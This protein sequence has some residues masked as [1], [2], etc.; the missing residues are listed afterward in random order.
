MLVKLETTLAYDS[1]N[2]QQLAGRQPPHNTPCSHNS[3]EDP[4][5]ESSKIF[6]WPGEDTDESV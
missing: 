4:E 5:V 2:C 6:F 1:L 3:N